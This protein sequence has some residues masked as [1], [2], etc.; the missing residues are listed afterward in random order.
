MKNVWHNPPSDRI[1]VDGCG[2]CFC[3]FEWKAVFDA[4]AGVADQGEPSRSKDVLFGL[5]FFDEVAGELWE[6]VS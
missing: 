3:F 6:G 5:I 2:F 4:R 1:L